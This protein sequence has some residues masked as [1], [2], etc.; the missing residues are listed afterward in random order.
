MNT[1]WTKV[2][3]KEMPLPEYPRPQMVRGNWINLNGL[4][5]FTINPNKNRPKHYDSSII[6]PYSPE[7]QLSGVCRKVKSHEYLWYRKT[8]ELPEGF[9]ED[10]LLLHIGAS[11]QETTIWI[12]GHEMG[13]F[14]GGYLPIDLD[15]TRYTDRKLRI[16]I[17]VSDKTERNGIS[18]G[19]Q[20]TKPGGVWYTAISGIWQTVWLESVPREYI[21]SVHI[22]PDVDNMLVHVYPEL[23]FDG[24]TRKPCYAEFNGKQFEVP[25]Y[26]P[27]E[28]CELWSPES[29][30]L[31]NFK[32]MFY[33]DEVE[34][35]FAMRKISVHRRGDE[36]PLV[37]LNNK[38]YFNNGI[39]DQGY[40]PDGLYTPPSDAAFVHDIITAKQFGFNMIRMHMKVE[41][42]R[43][44]YYCD[45][46][47]MLVWQDMPSGG[48]GK[49]N[50]L[51][52]VLPLFVNINFKDKNYRRFGR[53]DTKA[54]EHFKKEVLG[55]V[56]H[57]YSCPC[58]VTWV[59]F[60]EG[61]GQFD[62]ALISKAIKTYDKSRLIDHASGWHD[63]K[64]GDFLS[65]HK[66]VKPYRFK[67]DSHGR[68]VALTEF[69]GYAYV[70][71]GHTF[72]S[73]EFGYKRFDTENE[74]MEGIRELY[75]KQ[76]IPAIEKGLSVSVY[77]QLFDVEEEINGLM[78]YD[79]RITK[80]YPDE[81]R[82]ILSRCTFET[83]KAS[84]RSKKKSRKKAKDE[85]TELA[86]VVIPSGEQIETEPSLVIESNEEPK[87][88]PVAQPAAPQPE[89]EAEE[90]EIPEDEIEE[91]DNIE[92]IDEIDELDETDDI[93][94]IE[95][96]EVT[97]EIFEE[98]PPVKKELPKK[99]VKEPINK[100]ALR[101]PLPKKELSKD[102]PVKMSANKKELSDSPYFKEIIKEPAKKTVPRGTKKPRTA[103]TK[104]ET[105]KA[106]TKKSVPIKEPVK[107]DRKKSGN[108]TKKPK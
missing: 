66:Y 59:P 50:T 34:C 76:I 37:Y 85:Q 3:E 46:I 42:L 99:K 35:Y 38:P 22:T 94:E 12:N 67:P 44:Y 87:P 26:I 105:R 29:P 52:N 15:I 56:N 98:E 96:I 101:K 30:K 6:V 69:G 9:G 100:E 2:L 48:T 60:N 91:T 28:D 62:S 25:G 68:A 31:Y 82:K 45:R 92:E 13:T 61:W 18:R 1:P 84:K 64:A 79:R 107:K 11:D 40:W 104:T 54:R 21:K 27:T 8:V 24:E 80:L 108:S 36:K 23:D 95:E 103:D 19:K 4:W 86:P 77:T 89:I 14:L 5:D 65:T 17:R 57:L 39:L 49:L 81:V 32:I 7:S 88:M 102:K 70:V 72:N 63:N 51:S 58:I 41:A 90:P 78:T 55:M 53:A 83:E 106:G 93:E 73:K 20:R 74:L 97:P 43:W 71:Q 47:G 10:R 75:E 16:I 33:D